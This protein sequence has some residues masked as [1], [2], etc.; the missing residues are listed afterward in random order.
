M[1]L[2]VREIST[3]PKVTNNNLLGHA[4]HVV[5]I[6]YKDNSLIFQVDLNFN[7]ICSPLGE[8]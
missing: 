2:A 6:F 4:N 3:T 5:L 7:S 1:T 8:S